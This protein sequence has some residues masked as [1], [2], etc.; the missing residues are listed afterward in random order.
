M[1]SVWFKVLTTIDYRN[2][3][4]QTRKSTIDIEVTNLDSLIN[5]L[6]HLRNYFERV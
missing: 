6:T 2:K 4:L 1:P 3:V 5:D